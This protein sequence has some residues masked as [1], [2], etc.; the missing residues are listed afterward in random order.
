MKKRKGRQ[1]DEVTDYCEEERAL[2]EISHR[3]RQKGKARVKNDGYE[4]SNQDNGK[5]EKDKRTVAL[6]PS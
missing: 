4:M 1:K 3:R 2:M 5:K 6:K